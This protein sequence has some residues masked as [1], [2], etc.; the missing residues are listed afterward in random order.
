[1]LVVCVNPTMDRQIFLSA[2]QP[3]S[4]S[5]ARRNER[6][7]GGKPVDVLRAMAAHNFYPPL[8]VALPSNNEEYLGLLAAEGI[9]VESFEVPGDLRETIVLYEDSGRS[10]VVNGQGHPMASGVWTGL[11]DELV[12]RAADEDWVV[13]SGSFP[14]GVTGED[15]CN[16]V[17]AIHLAGARVALDSGPSWLRAAL[18]AKPDLITPNLAEAKMALRGEE[19]IEAVDVTEGAMAE[20][21]ETAVDL[22]ELGIAHVVVTAGSA[23]VAW[24][25]ASSQGSTAAFDVETVNPIGAGDAFLGGLMAR[26]AGGSPFADAVVWGVATAA[27]AV[28]Q[29]IPG[30]ADSEQVRSLMGCRT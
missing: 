19:G 3:G 24:A 25:M 12:R 6:L 15:V 11:A 26:M 4:V 27:S 30:R 22:V 20:A 5:R 9:T 23:G 18:P 16:L 13:L 2:L 17:R 1:M 14:P 28:T 7:A 10:T 29:W 21:E 8:L